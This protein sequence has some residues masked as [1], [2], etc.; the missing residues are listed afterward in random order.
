MPPDT[1]A[2]APN[3][4][5]MNIT[6]AVSFLHVLLAFA[7]IGFLVVPGYMLE[8]VAETRDVPFIRRAYRLGKFHGQIG[9]P[10]ALLAAIAGLIAAWRYGIP[11]TSG[12]LVVAY[13]AFVLVI[14]LGIGYHA[15]RE[16]R[17]AALAQTSPD[18]AP[19]PGLAAAIDE[20]MRWPLYWASAL[21]WIFLIWVMVAKPF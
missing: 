15:R 14:S 17:I 4:A 6:T 3:V 8:R 1:R 11:L 18:S 12:W 5:A 16:L 20:P 19:S 9:G 2:T 21:L 13:V 7:A 10:I